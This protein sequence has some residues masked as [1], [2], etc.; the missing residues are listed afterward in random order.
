M[1]V[2]VYT[3]TITLIGGGSQRDATA[4]VRNRA[5]VAIV[6]VA[7]IDAIAVAIVETIA[8]AKPRDPKLPDRE[9]NESRKSIAKP[10]K[11]R[12]N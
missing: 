3:G 7:I 6:A 1:R 4:V 12:S 5:S 8:A 10:I 11:A 9:L 2:S